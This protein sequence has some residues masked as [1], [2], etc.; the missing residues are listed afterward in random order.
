MDDGSEVHVEL[1]SCTGP[2]NLSCLCVQSIGFK[3][4]T[5]FGTD[6]QK[7]RYLPFV[8]SGEMLAAFCLTEPT[9][10]SD[11]S[12]INISVCCDSYSMVFDRAGRLWLIS[13]GH[14]LQLATPT[15]VDTYQAYVKFCHFA[16]VC[17]EQKFYHIAFISDNKFTIKYTELNYSKRKIGCKNMKKNG[18]KNKYMT[19][20]TSVIMRDSHS[21]KQSQWRLCRILHL[22]AFIAHSLYHHAI[23]QLLSQRRGSCQACIEYLIAS[24]SLNRGSVVNKYVNLQD[25]RLIA[26]IARLIAIKI[27]NRPTAL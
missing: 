27:F 19:T 10:G 21:V 23:V 17:V 8:S 24:L 4:I 14:H 1:D 25:C 3:G 16:V 26:V 9:S 7:Q 12:V 18:K 11:A 2:H 6:D 20:L 22:S 13:I 5:L 15:S